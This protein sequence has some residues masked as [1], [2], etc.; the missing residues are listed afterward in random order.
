MYL[1]LADSEIRIALFVDFSRRL[2]FLL[3]RLADI[4]LRLDPAPGSEAQL[5]AQFEVLGEC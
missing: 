5:N 2:G 3:R 4:A 1:T